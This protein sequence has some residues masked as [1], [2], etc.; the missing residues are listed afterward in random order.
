MDYQ[1]DQGGISNTFLIYI[2]FCNNKYFLING[3][4]LTKYYSVAK[5]NFENNYQF[6]QNKVNPDS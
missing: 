1:F 5:D 4:S 2:I 6:F 3:S